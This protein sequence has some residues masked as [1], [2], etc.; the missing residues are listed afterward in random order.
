[1]DVARIVTRL[2]SNDIA[3]LSRIIS[4]VEQDDPQCIPILKALFP[5]TGNARVIGV[6]GS[7]GVGKSTLIGQLVRQYR[8]HG[9]R[10]AV[11]AVDPSSRI[12]GGATLGDRI[13]MQDAGND[14]YIF[15]RSMANRGAFGGLAPTTAEVVSVLDSTGWDP[16]FVETIGTGQDQ[17]EIATVATVVIALLMPRMGDEV[18]FAKAGMLEVADIF[19]LNKCDQEA[20]ELTE[21]YLRD[22]IAQIHRVDGWSPALVKTSAHNGAGISALVDAISK[23]VDYL[24]ADERRWT[25]KRTT[26]WR[27]FL[28]RLLQAHI[29]QSLN[30]DWEPLLTEYASAIAEKRTDPFT[31]VERLLGR[32][33][34][35][36]DDV[37]RQRKA[38]R[39][40]AG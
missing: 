4:L 30:H 3:L 38:P 12:S 16:I 39:P 9:E 28:D 17:L 19:V 5:F 8:N 22:T 1:M 6:T 36:H 26:Q 32:N 31:V 15:I 20:T 25:S 18:Q 14:P 35:P 7:P 13:R 27:S 34:S 23:Y 33:T 2:R 29:L 24:D 21:L 40:R 37:L 10:V 11:V